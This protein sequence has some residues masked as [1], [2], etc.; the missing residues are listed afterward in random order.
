MYRYLTALCVLAS[1]MLGGPRALATLGDYTF[2]VSS[3][4]AASMSNATSLWRGYAGSR[5]GSDVNNVVTGVDLPFTFRFDG[6]DYRRISVSSNGLIGF[7]GNDV[8]STN[9]NSLYN[10]GSYPA[11]TAWWDQLTLTGGAQNYC[12][13][14]PEVLWSVNGSAPN[15]VV[16][17]EWRDVEVTYGTAAFSTFQVRLYE[18]S[19]AI[20][21]YYDDMTSV[22]CQSWNSGWNWTGATIGLATSDADV[23]T[24]IPDYSSAYLNRGGSYDW[25]DMSQEQFRI[26]ANTIYRFSPCN[27]EL[28][29]D[30]RQGGTDRMADGDVLM[31]N[32]VTQRGNSEAFQPFT[33]ANGMS[34]C[35]PRSFSMSIEGDA[36]AEYRLDIEGGY[37]EP[38]TTIIPTITFSPTGPGVRAATLIITDDNYFSRTF[39][40]A[41][42][43][44]SRIEW[45]PLISDGATPGLAD[46]DT[47]MRTIEVPRRTARDLSPITLLNFNDNPEASPALVSVSIDSLGSPSTQYELIGPTTAALVAGQ[48]FTPVIRFIGEGVGPQF[49]T[50]TVVADDETRV[51]TL[52]A[53]SAAPAI[54][55]KANGVTVDA[56]NPAMNLAL[57]C[58]GEN[59]LTV[60]FTVNNYGVLPLVINDIDVYQTDTTIT[61]GAPPFPLLRNA[62]GQPIPMYDYVISATPGGAPLSLPYTVGRGETH[63]LY[64]TYTGAEPGKRFGRMFIRTNAQNLYGQETTVQTNMVLG[65]FTTDVTARATGSQLAANVSGLSLKP[66]VFPHT[67]VGDSTTMSFAIANAGA[68]DLR[69]NRTKLRIQSGDVNEFRML[70][71]LRTARIDQ[72]T[73]DFVLAP[74]MVDTI[75]IRFLPSRAGTRLATLRL[76]TNDSS[77]TRPGLVERGTYYLDLHGRGLAGLDGSDLSLAPVVIGGSV[78][79]TA[80][81]ENT[82]NVA[83]GIDRAFFDGGDA[84]EF[85]AVN[86]PAIPA[87]V[88]PGQKLQLGVRLTPVGTAG[89]RRTTL[90]LI[91]GGGDTVRVLVRGE[92]GTQTLAVSPTGMFGDVSIAVGQTKRQT[93]MISNTGT[94]PV[95]IT[96]V[97]ISG[98]DASSYRAGTLPRRDLEAGQTEYLELTYAPTAPGQTSAELVVTA[99]NGMTYTVALGGT[100][101][102]IRRDPIDPVMTGSPNADGTPELGERRDGVEIPTLR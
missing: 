87:S 69:I 40:L 100:A 71:S 82:L 84:A 94:L 70:T 80:V 50:L 34:G 17:I 55:V 32:I 11:I 13:A 26:P 73:G 37:I 1:L 61:Q 24:V 18:G 91:T 96:G 43:A 44:G 28:V 20:E 86:W 3:G 72:A 25:V 59:A 67:R 48:S 36:A 62:Q 2:E 29:G 39:T 93:L 5:R 21:F 16:A 95:V 65:L 98:A 19:N 79:G 35:G 31:S 53:V 42:N 51:Y 85:S 77:I 12:T 54:A 4:S 57:T 90:V 30:T 74:G 52:L 14:A 81:L 89:V 6:I 75:S 64:L 38:G 58:V 8:S 99:S 27:I 41:A 22:G 76:Q 47:L 10:T 83:V 66:V 97:T 92:A 101:L 60:P 88:L 56:E 78:E 7:G 15:R 68:C 33:I 63:Q 49:A 46:G 102:K 23:M 9:G 45:M